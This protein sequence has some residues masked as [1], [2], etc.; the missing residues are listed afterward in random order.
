MK[1]KICKCGHT[2]DD[3]EDYILPENCPKCE[4]TP[5]TPCSCEGQRC[6]ICFL[7]QRTQS[8]H[9]ERL[10]GLWDTLCKPLCPLWL[11]MNL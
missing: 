1:P 7:P 8:T 2:L 3:H 5:N 11:I 4:G 10:E 9:E 6:K